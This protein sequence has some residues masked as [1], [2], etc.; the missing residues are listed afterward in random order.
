M[1]AEKSGDG[2]DNPYV[3]FK[4]DRERKWALVSRDVRLVLVAAFSAFGG[5]AL[6]WKFIASI[7]NG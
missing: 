5:G 3:A 2:S 4:S 1:S 6:L 7:T